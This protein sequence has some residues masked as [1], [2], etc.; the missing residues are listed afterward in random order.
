MV[1]PYKE[2]KIGLKHLKIAKF[3]LFWHCHTHIKQ[4]NSGN[5]PYDTYSLK[6]SNT[7]VKVLVTFF[8]FWQIFPLTWQFLSVCSVSN[9]KLVIYMMLR[10]YA[11]NIY[12]YHKLFWWSSAK[13]LRLCR[14]CRKTWKKSEECQKKK[15]SHQGIIYFQNPCMESFLFIHRI[16]PCK[17]FT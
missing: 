15:T 6:Y 2:L 14:N 17:R 16:T 8:N 1:G 11:F 7:F 5:R 12:S 4:N 9:V 13:K 3:G 10:H